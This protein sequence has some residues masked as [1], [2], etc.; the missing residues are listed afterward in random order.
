MYFERATYEGSLLI[1]GSPQL[2]LCRLA[3]QLPPYSQL[4][5]S[6]PEAHFRS[7]G[8]FDAAVMQCPREVELWCGHCSLTGSINWLAFLTTASLGTGGAPSLRAV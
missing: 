1:N 7:T 3:D 8:H 6:L 5:L 4:P 2:Q